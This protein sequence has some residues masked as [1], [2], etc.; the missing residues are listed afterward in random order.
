MCS[1]MTVHD[2]TTGE[3]EIVRHMDSIKILPLIS[4][5]SWNATIYVP[6]AKHIDGIMMVYSF[7]KILR[8]T[9]RILLHH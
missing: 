3:D 8:C 2:D 4:P 9:K 5:R 6:I 7:V 1:Y